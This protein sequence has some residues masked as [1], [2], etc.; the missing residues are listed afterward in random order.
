MTKS[1]DH[2]DHWVQE[3]L[4]RECSFLFLESPRTFKS[5]ETK[6]FK[7]E[8]EQL[9]QKIL[10][11]RG[12]FDIA[13]LACNGFSGI[14]GGY[15]KRLGKC[16]ITVGNILYLWFGV[17]TKNDLKYRAD[18]VKLYMNKHWCQLDAPES[19][20]IFEYSW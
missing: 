13:F 8:T 4:L 10:A 3:R 1:N 15:I 16:S 18:M 9:A 11:L 7:K 20:S 14:M 2:P 5:T 17:Y 19:E 12:Q 6:D